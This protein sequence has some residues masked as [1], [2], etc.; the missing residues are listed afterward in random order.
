MQ[1]WLSLPTSA[2]AA[3]PLTILP[4]NHERRAAQG[5]NHAL[6]KI[7]SLVSEHFTS[8]ESLKAELVEVRERSSVMGG[9]YRQNQ[10]LEELRQTRSAL[11]EEKR[12]WARQRDEQELA[13]E[14]S[15]REL[16]RTQ[17][18][19]NIQ[20]ITHLLDALSHVFA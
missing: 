14:K 6:S 3:P 12:E 20:S 11:R 4:G 17:Q 2:A 18:E 19:V 1:R 8:L 13:M 9:R 10:L 15:R 5:V 7:M 16:A